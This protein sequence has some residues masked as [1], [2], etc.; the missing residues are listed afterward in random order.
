MHAHVHP[1][2]SRVCGDTER[3]KVAFIGRSGGMGM[4]NRCARF[5][6]H[7]WPR[8]ET[9]GTGGRYMVPA[10][11]TQEPQPTHPA[12][13]KGMHG[14][15]H[16]ADR[17]LPSPASH[18]PTTALCCFLTLLAGAISRHSPP[19]H[20][21][22]LP[23]LHTHAQCTLVSPLQNAKHGPPGQHHLVRIT[24]ITTTVRH[25]PALRPRADSLPPSPV[26]ENS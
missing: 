8:S 1:F 13:G 24:G 25:R 23:A 6:A 18:V 4:M 20:S 12:R 11:T 15:F 16:C 26:H 10:L 21:F 14:L 2:L 5:D 17:G 3:K 22:N 7:G 19:R 9:R